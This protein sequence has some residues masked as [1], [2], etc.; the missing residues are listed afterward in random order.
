M[1]NVVIAIAALLVLTLALPTQMARAAAPQTASSVPEDPWIWLEA[2]HDPK[3]L[4]WARQHTHKATKALKALPI[5]PAVHQ[6]MEQVLAAAQPVPD[7]TLLGDKATRVLHTAE[8]PHGLL[9]TAARDSHGIPGSWHTVLDVAALRAAEDTPWVLQSYSLA[10][11]CLPPEFD[12]CLLRLSLGGGDEVQIREFDLTTGEFVEDGF[13]VP[14][15][16][17]FAVWL[18]K[19]HLLVETTA[20]GAATTAAGWPAEVRVWQRGEPLSDAQAVYTA[21]PTD[22]IVALDVMG[23]GDWR[24]GI[25]TR[26][27]DYST[28]ETLLVDVSGNV[29]KTS[30]P[31]SL[32]MSAMAT[33]DRFLVVQLGAAATVEG[34]EYPAESLLAYAIEPDS[35]GH[36]ISLVHTPPAGHFVTNSRDI[37]ATRDQV[38]FITS[39][40][41]V[42]R[43]MAASWDDQQQT[44][45]VHEV[46]Q[47]DPGKT[48]TFQQGAGA[49]NSLIVS[50]SGFVT[51]KQQQLYRPGGTLATLAVDPTLFNGSEYVTEIHSAIS[52]DGTRIDYY[53]L[54][55]RNSPWQGAQPTL[56]T[57][58]AAFGIS[59]RPGYFGHI[60]GGRSFKLWLDRGGSLVVPAAR[61]GG[62]R[63]DA[64][65]RAA[66]REKRQNSYDDFIAVLE[67]LIDEG[68]TTPSRLGVFGSSNGGLMAAVMATQRP[69]LF[70][71]VVSDVPLTDLFRMKY[72]GMG[73][74]WLN[75]YGD[76]ANPLYATILS[77]YSPYQNVRQGVDY[78]PIMVTSST[79][80]NR[81]GP[82]HARK[83]AAKLESVGATVYLLEQQ[84][85]GHGVSNAFSN[86]QLMSLRMTFLI[87]ELMH[88]AD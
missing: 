8:H 73:A 52:R 23:H 88:K 79:E 47:A 41:L 37:A 59:I 51:P 22:A 65:H 78:P 68:Y 71:A 26:S 61:G 12:R 60:V 85:G 53:L 70:S 84:E 32:K 25:I 15:S 5:Y 35:H 33:T 3:A 16:R 21:E 36:H 44:W 49:G 9:Q 34:Q 14:T 1:K 10:K 30:L 69:D 20:N 57:G 29:H 2:P 86:P 62:E 82:G 58:Y 54:K 66:M 81:V 19:N 48:L 7:I 28:F 43:L 17:A 38:L 80:D 72:M 27:I 40:R 18:D 75:E 50:L 63:G 31:R 39:H 55:P 45:E 6:Q 4:A 67:E 83:F 42:Q 56:M 64:W 74:A 77:R 24:R 11:A 13:V 76:P 87:S 46:L